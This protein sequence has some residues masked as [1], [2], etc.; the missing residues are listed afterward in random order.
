V[1]SHTAP[2]Q[3][4]RE[5]E[6]EVLGTTFDLMAYNDEDRIRTTLVDGSVKVVSN[7]DHKLLSPR[8]R[9]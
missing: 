3:V 2:E 1:L 6:I 9:R 7:A 5:I 8:S 4:T